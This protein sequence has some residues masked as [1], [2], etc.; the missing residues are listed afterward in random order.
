[1]RITMT[2]AAAAASTRALCTSVATA[3]RRAGLL[4]G[5]GRIQ[6][7]MRRP[8]LP[9][10]AALTGAILLTACQGVSSGAAAP[11]ATVPATTASHPAAPAASSPPAPASPPAD[12]GSSSGQGGHSG[13]GGSSGQGGPS[14]QGGS[15]GSARPG[16]VDCGKSPDALEIRPATVL[17]ACADGTAGL[18]GMTWSTW[19]PAV[20]AAGKLGTATGTGKFWVNDCSPSCAQGHDQTYPVTVT[21]SVVASSNDG[22][23]FQICT[24]KFPAQKPAADA[25]TR[26]TLPTPGVRGS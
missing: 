12:T 22:N 24:L 11:P 7:M 3:S 23:F 6:I 14:G 8:F 17:L 15:P 10:A 19:Q 5:S 2:P 21:L 25:R 1:M 18:R 9:L 20:T 26:W 4:S 13:Q 16:V